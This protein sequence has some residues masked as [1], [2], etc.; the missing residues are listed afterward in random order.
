[1]T[2]ILLKGGIWTQR[3]TQREDRVKA[4]GDHNGQVKGSRRTPEA[5]REAW[6]RDFLITLEGVDPA[7]ALILSF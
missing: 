2:D 3:H 6:N 5:K 1:M 4:Q 7:G